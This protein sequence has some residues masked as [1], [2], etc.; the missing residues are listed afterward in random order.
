VNRFTRSPS[1]TA[2]GAVAL[3]IERRAVSVLGGA[4]CYG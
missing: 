1:S 3:E 2:G 4:S